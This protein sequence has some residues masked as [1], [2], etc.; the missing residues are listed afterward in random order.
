MK[1]R[2]DII[3]TYQT[4]HHWTGIIA[5]FVLFIGFYAGSLTMFKPAF[6]QWATPSNNTFSTEIVPEPQ[7]LLNAV[8]ETETSNIRTIELNLERGNH[9]MAPISWSKSGIKRGLDIDQQ[10]FIATFDNEG[11]LIKQNVK[12]TV[13]AELI[14]LLH[15]T[16]GI[17]GRV[18]H[19]DLGVLIMGGAALLYFL[20]LVS[21]VIFLLP[22]LVKSFLA[23]RENKGVSRFWL[24][25][26][27]IIGL[28]SLPFHLIISWTVVVFAFHDIVY[29]SMGQVIYGDKPLFEFGVKDERV[30]TNN[31]LLS[32]ESLN[33][34]ASDIAPQAQVTSM[35]FDG[36]TTPRASVRLD[37]HIDNEVMRG[38]L[39]DMLFL[40]P[41]SGDVIFGSVA[42]D[43]DPIWAE[44]V[45]T[46][47]AMHFG[48]YGGNSVRWVYFSLGI[49]GA[50]LFY[51]G[52]L[53]WIERRRVKQNKRN[54]KPLSEIKQTKVAKRMA[55]AT[56]GIC[57]G[58]IAALTI[59]MLF[60]KWA[61]NILDN[62]NQYYIA[63]YYVLFIC[64]VI[65]TFW[66][67]AS[68]GA[69]LLTKVTA[70][71]L[72]LMPL[73]SL[74]GWIFPNDILWL[75]SAWQAWVIDIMALIFSVLFL[76]MA[77]KIKHRA[78][79]GEPDSVWA[80]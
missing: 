33:K 28:T 78:I 44:T 3:R 42:T 70:L 39:A 58:S 6:E 60:G 26:H 24:D 36:L 9:L 73:T 46:F 56:V 25:S 65:Y 14:D 64:S 12:P 32:I 67:G 13:V 61:T 34:I 66:R 21:G 7:R 30:F 17:P 19:D 1:V 77:K 10:R 51:S 41:Y 49:F 52:N 59:T 55:A 48:S 11:E 79:Y 5:G 43:N 20:A 8:L 75:A 35:Y 18:G 47:F 80:Y 29:G 71:G 76:F 4:L 68:V 74:I 62:V 53:L 23:L 15:R 31:D 40:N 45:A 38:P 37:L 72:L 16:A 50:V 22:T 63:S 2:A 54:P 27:N 69:M 57:L